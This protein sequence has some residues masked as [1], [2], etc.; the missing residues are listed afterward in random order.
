MRN[1]FQ[2]LMIWIVIAFLTGC[3][4]NEVSIHNSLESNKQEQEL[5]TKVSWKV[6]D[7]G[8]APYFHLYVTLNDAQDFYAG[9]FY[10]ENLETG[11]YADT[12]DNAL[13][14]VGATW[15]GVGELFYIYQ[16]N[17]TELALMNH[18]APYGSQPEE[19]EE[20]QEIITISI[21]EGSKIKIG[22]VV[23]EQEGYVWSQDYAFIIYDGYVLGGM[24]KSENLVP[25]FE[26]DFN[27]YWQISGRWGFRLFQDGQYLDTV[28]YDGFDDEWL[29]II[30]TELKDSGK[31]DSMVVKLNYKGEYFD[32]L[33]LNDG[34]PLMFSPKI[35]MDSS[36]EVY[37]NYI[38][39][40]LADNG[41]D[42]ETVH[43]SEIVKTD[44]EGDGIDEV[45]IIA[46]NMNA[47]DQLKGQYLIVVLQ[48]IMDDKV[49]S[50]FLKKHITK[51]QP[52]DLEERLTP[53]YELREVVDLD[54]DGVCELL[55]AETWHE[56]SSYQVY[57]M[58]NGEMQLILENGFQVSR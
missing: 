57:K 32:G 1:V 5:V 3:S 49:E 15:A 22:N 8:G 16:K 26:A 50:I 6:I 24:D 19:W 14:A 46:S 12:P 40:I 55:L 41:L 2:L 33:A 53:D 47:P 27:E 20:Y 54:H 56:G 44:L 21:P 30:E 34:S 7:Y 58:L 42:E 25:A 23:D 13:T 39:E 36:T 37:R 18:H 29:Q 28:S 45:F 31:V 52:E 17:E 38:S 11:V 4:N 35:S 51:V 43:I 48:K 10:G 9:Y